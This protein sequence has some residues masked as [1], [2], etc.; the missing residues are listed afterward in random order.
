[1]QDW[2]AIWHREL[3][4]APPVE[5]FVAAYFDYDAPVIGAEETEDDGELVIDLPEFEG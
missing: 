5:A 4:E 1:L 2:R 3:I